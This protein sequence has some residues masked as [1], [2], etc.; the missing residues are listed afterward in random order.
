MPTIYIETTVVSYLTAWTSRDLVRAAQQRLTRDWW[1]TQRSRFDVFTSELVLLECGAG[2][3]TAAADRL[4]VLA[5]LPA[6]TVSDEASEVA[7]NLVARGAIP[8]VAS[9]DALHVG[10]C[11][12]NGID[13]L[14]TWNFKHLANAAMRDRI[15]EA[16]EEMGYRSP[17][18][19][20]PDALFEEKS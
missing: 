15:A 16:C 4:A 2:D 3:A 12:V 18:I 9:R 8:I 13:F 11:C 17:V 5:G 19:C 7:N 20:A 1:D 10:I 14:L 6:L